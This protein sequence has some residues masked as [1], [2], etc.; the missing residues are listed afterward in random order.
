MKFLKN[1]VVLLLAFIL[2]FC[3]GLGFLR[4]DTEDVFFSMG[5][6]DAFNPEG[7]NQ[8][9]SEQTCDVLDVVQEESP[10][11]VPRITVVKSNRQER[12]SDYSTDQ[13]ISYMRPLFLTKSASAIVSFL[14]HIPAAS[15]FKI[16]KAIVQDST[17]H[18][19]NRV[20]Y[21]IIFAAAQRQRTGTDKFAYFDLIAQNKLLQKGVKPLLVKAVE[22]GYSHL[23]HDILD[24]SETVDLGDI[25]HE[26]LVYAARHDD[27]DPEALRELFEAG[28]P[29]NPM[30]ATELLCELT[31][32]CQHGYSIP[33][34]AQTLGAD[35]IG[36]LERARITSNIKMEALL[37]RYVA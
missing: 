13:L 30:L 11:A 33:F 26:A 8:P 14:K 24:W 2:L 25:S 18:L 10:A 17:I 31:N 22:A 21:R 37:N 20:K 19:P 36:T 7:F 35:F 3:F 34:L 28:V 32:H 29:V 12:L 1:D 9:V 5:S 23:V 4:N 15:V 16:V 6:L 27:E